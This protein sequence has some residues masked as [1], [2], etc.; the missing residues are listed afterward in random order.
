M[1]L[2]NFWLASSREATPPNSVQQKVAKHWTT[3]HPPK[4]SPQRRKTEAKMARN[5][6]NRSCW[7]V[8]FLQA[9]PQ[10]EEYP[11]SPV[12]DLI[13]FFEHFLK[14]HWCDVE[15]GYWM[16]VDFPWGENWGGNCVFI[17]LFGDVTRNMRWDTLDF[18]DGDMIGSKIA[19]ICPNF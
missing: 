2:A 16:K 9:C 3:K 10:I 1:G 12:S 18:M 17:C 6:A 13:Y 4:Q 5:H 11:Y 7:I 19:R 15:T 8:F 14:T